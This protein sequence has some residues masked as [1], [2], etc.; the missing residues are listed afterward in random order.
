MGQTRSE[1]PRGTTRLDDG[2]RNWLVNGL[3]EQLPDVLHIASYRM[4]RL[5]HRFHR[6]SIVGLGEAGA[7]LSKVGGYRHHD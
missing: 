3:N 6:L 5:L 1:R 4:Q 7:L 2:R